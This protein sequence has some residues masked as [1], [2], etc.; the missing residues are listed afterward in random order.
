MSDLTF[1]ER[2]EYLHARISAKM[3]DR[4]TALDYL[5]EISMKCA[6]TRCKQMLLERDIPIMPADENLFPTLKELVEMSSGI[7]IAFVNPHVSVD[8]A[9]KHLDEYNLGADFKYFN[10]AAEAQ[11]WLLGH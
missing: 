11:R 2:P 1:D 3:L 5:S 9:M 4:R 10:D 6:N 8:D 7:R